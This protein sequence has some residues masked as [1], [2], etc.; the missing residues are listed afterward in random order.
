MTRPTRDASC[1]IAVRKD[2]RAAIGRLARQRKMSVSAL[3]S[4]RLG[5]AFWTEV[6][7]E[8][9][10]CKQDAASNKESGDEQ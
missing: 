2:Q 7:K 6:D 9:L 4:M 3:L 10:R 5:R 8:I 1:F